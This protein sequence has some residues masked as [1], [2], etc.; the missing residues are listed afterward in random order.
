M[1]KTTQ[2]NSIIQ[3]I[4]SGQWNNDDI[5]ILRQLL[6]DSDRDSLQQLGKYNVSVG[7]GKEIHIGDRIYPQWDE[8]A[9]QALVQSIRE[10]LDEVKASSTQNT[11]NISGGTI[12][13]LSGS[14]TIQ[15]HEASPQQPR[16][17]N[18]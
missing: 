16:Q 13:N 8:T 15:Y 4:V 18:Q 10:Q 1:K 12:T 9:I 3:Q 2:M 5:E 6:Q 11:F 7:E 14:G 17:H